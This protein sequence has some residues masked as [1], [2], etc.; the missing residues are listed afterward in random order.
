MKPCEGNPFQSLVTFHSAFSSIHSLDIFFPFGHCTNFDNLREDNK[1]AILHYVA[2]SKESISAT[3]SII[4]TQ[5]IEV[6]TSVF[7]ADS[8]VGC[9][10]ELGSARST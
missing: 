8:V 7:R 9:T 2:Q 1:Q 4:S 10:Y 5:S 3:T 6:S